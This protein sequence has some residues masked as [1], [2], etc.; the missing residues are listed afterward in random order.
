MSKKEI[1][2]RDILRLVADREIGLDDILVIG[3]VENSPAWKARGAWTSPVKI[4]KKR[5]GSYLVIL[6]VDTPSG[7]LEG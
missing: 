7:E 1:T 3:N 4:R 2:P 6:E 5:E